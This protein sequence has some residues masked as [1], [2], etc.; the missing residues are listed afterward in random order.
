MSKFWIAPDKWSHGQ[1][2]YKINIY[3]KDWKLFVE[4]DD[5]WNIKT[6]INRLICE[7][8]NYNKDWKVLE[9]DHDL[10]SRLNNWIDFIRWEISESTQEI[11]EEL[12]YSKKSA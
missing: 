9:I 7:I 1:N 5:E 12:Y 4:L 8:V 10:Y 11:L 2:L 6:N 3:K